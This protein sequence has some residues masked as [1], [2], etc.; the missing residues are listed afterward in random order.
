VTSSPPTVT[1]IVPPTATAPP[2][3]AGTSDV[4]NAYFA[5]INAGDYARAW[6]LGGTNLQGGSY[7]SFVQGFATTSHD[8]VTILSVTGETATIHLDA[9]QTDGTH[10]YFAGTYTVRGGAIVAADIRQTSS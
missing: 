4:V 6:A 5:A 10:R 1:V 2:S 9:L 7:A 8:S 3:P